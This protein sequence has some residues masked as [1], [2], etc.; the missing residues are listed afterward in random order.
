[1]RLPI[2]IVDLISSFNGNQTELYTEKGLRYI[3]LVDCSFCS[4]GSGNR[5]E[6]F[7]IFLD[8][9]RIEKSFLLVKLLL[10]NISYWQEQTNHWA[11]EK[12]VKQIL[13]EVIK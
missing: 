2:E 12:Q 1:M 3:F 11:T 8:L 6:T 13:S 10:K 4:W 7:H 9:Y 5:K